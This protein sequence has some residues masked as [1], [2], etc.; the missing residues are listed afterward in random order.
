MYVTFV[1]VYSAQYDQGYISETR[2]KYWPVNRSDLS[3]LD[4]RHSPQVLRPC[5]IFA[6]Y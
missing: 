1:M 3:A 6:F 5:G 4:L 2:N